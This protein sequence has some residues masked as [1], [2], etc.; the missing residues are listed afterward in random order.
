MLSRLPSSTK[1][2]FVGDPEPVQE[3]PH[4]REEHR[5][6]LL[7]VVHRYDDGER[8]LIGSHKARETTRAN[9][10]Q[11]WGGGGGTDH[12]ISH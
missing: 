4:P 3:R 6:H 2:E 12:A 5:Q 1:S 11:S 10:P 8:R 9:T 7:L